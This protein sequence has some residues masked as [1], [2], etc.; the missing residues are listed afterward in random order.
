MTTH[1]F[2]QN[3]WAQTIHCTFCWC[4]LGDRAANPYGVIRFVIAE[5]EEYY[6]FMRNPKDVRFDRVIADHENDVAG[7]VLCATCYEHSPVL[8]H[9]GGVVVHPNPGVNAHTPIYQSL[10]LS[11]YHVDIDCDST[12]A[13]FVSFR[14]R[15]DI[16]DDDDWE[17]YAAAPGMTLP[18]T[19]LH[20]TSV[21]REARPVLFGGFIAVMELLT[22]GTLP[23]LP[24]AAPSAR[25]AKRQRL[26]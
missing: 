12:G 5:E 3:A 16:F 24:A 22:W 25:G 13:Q 23:T 26:N 4:D 10:Y 7:H 18:G 14:C 1:L 2:F 11:T 21:Y 20:C 15:P 8:I 6:K 9:L 19:P 17:G